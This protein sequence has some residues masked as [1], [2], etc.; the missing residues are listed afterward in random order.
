MLTPDLCFPFVQDQEAEDGNEEEEE[1]G[2]EEERKSSD[3]RGRPKKKIKH[4][5]EEKTGPQTFTGI[6]IKV[7]QTIA[8][9]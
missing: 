2:E 5:V 4:A 9:A 1:E 8:H 7:T 3:R 6:G